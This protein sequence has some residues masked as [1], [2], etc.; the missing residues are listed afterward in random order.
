MF[1]YLRQHSAHLQRLLRLSVP[2]IAG[3]LGLVFMGFFDNLMVGQLG[4]VYLA[5][6]GVANSVY[7]VVSIIGIGILMVV[8]TLVSMLLGNNENEQIPSLLRSAMFLSLLITIVLGAV[9][10]YLGSH[11]EWFRQ[12]AEVAAL[13]EP[14]LKILIIAQLPMYMY[15]GLKGISD[16]YE[17]TRISMLV[18]L[19]ALLLNIFLNWLLIYGHWG[20]PALEL[21]GAGYATLIS[22]VFMA[23]AMLYFVSRSSK[24]AIPF[25]SL[26]RYKRS[27]DLR[28]MKEI[29]RLG[30]PSGFQFFFEVAAFALAAVMAGWINAESLAAHQAAISLAS[31]TYMFA[32]GIA[33]GAGITVG[34]AMGQKDFKT[35]RIYGN[36]SL[37]IIFSCMFIF[38]LIFIVF[39]SYL[40]EMFVHES[41]VYVIAVDLML[42]AAAFQI[43]DGVQAVN[44]G[45]LRGIRDVKT[46]LWVTLMAYWAI[47]IPVGYYIG[48][49]LKYG[50]FGIWIGL[51]S[52]LVITASV[53]TR[54]FYVR[55]R[56][57]HS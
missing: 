19:F 3:Q 26:F 56:Q 27:L 47:A 5:A 52:G 50:I 4:H 6:A 31:V 29:L 35:I 53:L 2:L 37:G 45:I 54:R 13:A 55:L 24:I 16:G 8:S 18:T 48:I 49:Y 41:S 9:L 36:L 1:A 22:R 32:T 34:N 46:P 23:I 12:P 40:I 15:L 20:F 14:Y 25:N 33:A 42:L 39:R 38:G 28:Q 43:F 30:V 11:F 17:M 10:W 51:T 21:D 44:L 7:F 57:L